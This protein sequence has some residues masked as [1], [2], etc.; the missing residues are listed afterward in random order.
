MNLAQLPSITRRRTKRIGRGPGSGKG[1]HTVGR[2]TKG[3]GARGR[4]GPNFFG[5]AMGASYIKRLPLLRGKGKLKSGVK[6]MGI[7][8]DR[9]NVLPPKSTVD[10]ALLVKHAIVASPEAARRGLKILG[11]GNITVSLTVMLPATESARNKIEKAGGRVE[12]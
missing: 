7:N 1:A 4:I 6:P 12:R 11:R 9:L 10:V 3:R 8:V 2:G 5:T